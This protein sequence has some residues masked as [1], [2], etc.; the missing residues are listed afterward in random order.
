[1]KSRSHISRTVLVLGIAS[2]CADLSSEMIYPLLPVFLSTVIG[3]SV[4]QLGIIEGVAESVA[5]MGKLVSGF[6]ADRVRRR[7]PFLVW[8]YSISSFIRPL[9]GLSSTWVMVLACRFIDRIGKGLRT[10]PRDALIADVTPSHQRGAAFGFHRAMD[11]AGAVG[12]PLIASALLLIPGMSLRNVFLFAAIPAVVTMLVLIIFLK[13]PAR[14]APIK[15]EGR[16]RL[17]DFKFFN[18]N[19]RTFL[20]ALLL[21]TL[22]N[23]TDAFIL[24]RLNQAG[25]EMKWIAGLWSLHHVVKMVSTY[26]GGRLS[27][28]WGRKGPMVLGWLLFA[29]VYV[30]FAL[31][32]SAGALVAVFLIYGVFYGLTEPTEKAIIADIAPAEQRGSAFGSYHFVMSIAALPASLIFGLI[33]QKVGMEAAFGFGAALALIAALILRTIPVRAPA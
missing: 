28:S 23:S 4:L 30:G 9:I 8:G 17:S 26:Y 15:V 10:S 14:P 13:E 16:F 3:A 5:A 19:L 21:F 33:W 29:A 2:L 32:E 1:M 24:V 20:L 12:G 18:K 25:I 31:V 22:G 6:W 7:K 27:D 11:H